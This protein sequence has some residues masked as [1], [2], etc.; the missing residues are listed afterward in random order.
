M[1]LGIFSI[2]RPGTLARGSSCVNVVHCTMHGTSSLVIDYMFSTEWYTTEF[3]MQVSVLSLHAKRVSTT[4]LF[5]PNSLFSYHLQMFFFWRFSK[6]R[7]LSQTHS[8]DQCTFHTHTHITSDN[9]TGMDKIII[10][11]SHLHGVH[12]NHV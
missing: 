11:L 9:S 3:I 10:Y 6:Q 12:K 1:P 5:V 8:Q 7:E 2:I 4:A